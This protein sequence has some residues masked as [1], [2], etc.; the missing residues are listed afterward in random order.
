MNCED[1]G[2]PIVRGEEAMRGKVEL[3]DWCINLDCPSNALPTG[4]H[5]IGVLD[6]TCDTCGAVITSGAEEAIA[7]LRQHL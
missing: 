4:L 1:C 2:S 5:R 7:H 3:V 6:Y